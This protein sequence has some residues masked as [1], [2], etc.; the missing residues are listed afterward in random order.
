MPRSFLRLTLTSCSLNTICLLGGVTPTWAAPPPGLASVLPQEPSN[1]REDA[2]TFQ[3]AGLRQS[4][5]QQ[6]S[7]APGAAPP[8]QE[9]A[10]AHST[11]TQG[12][13]KHPSTDQSAPSGAESPKGPNATVPT[14]APLPPIADRA[15]EGPAA[16]EGP[17]T[18]NES[19]PAPP[20]VEP[21]DDYNSSPPPGATELPPSSGG[22]GEA[23]HVALELTPAPQPRKPLFNTLVLAEAVAKYGG[24]GGSLDHE[25]DNSWDGRSTGLV[26]GQMTLGLMP[27]GKY[28]TMAARLSGGVFLNSEP[29]QSTIGA[30]MLFGANFIRNARGDTYSYAL[31]GAGVEFLPG[32][33]QDVL[34]FHLVGGTVV[35]GMS[36]S[37]GVDLGTNEEVGFAIFGLQLG[38]GHLY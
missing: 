29:A 12:D 11:P 2:S 3:H 25:D 27:G 30:S 9:L 6:E 15:A 33:N 36:F 31:A 32:L 20:V 13:P 28:F 37:A 24:F 21:E 4:P 34:A 23:G 19:A 38:W 35:G 22:V 10:T 18:K 7:S 16:T 1:A 14:V 26:G 5:S 8:N 17:T